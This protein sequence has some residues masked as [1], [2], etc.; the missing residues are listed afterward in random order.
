MSKF[1]IY[2]L[3]KQV[4]AELKE[5]MRDQFGNEPNL[6]EA[7]PD[8]V[9]VGAA[10]VGSIPANE[11][12]CSSTDRSK[13]RECLPKQVLFIYMKAIASLRRKP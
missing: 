1:L 3:P 5:T 9:F 11:G 10:C 7:R 13:G 4:S 6:E 12:Y 2:P 8:V